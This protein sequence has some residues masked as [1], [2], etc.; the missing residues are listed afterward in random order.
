VPLLGLALLATMALAIVAIIPQPSALSTRVDGVIPRMAIRLGPSAPDIVDL[1]VGD[2]A[3]YTLD[4][5]EGAVRAFSLD[6]LEQQPTPETLLARAGTALDSLG[7]QLALPIAI[8]YLRGPPNEPGSLAIVDQSRAVIQVGN[9]RTLSAHA[10]STSADWQ[11]LGALGSG[12]K[13]ELL[14]LDSGAQQVLAYPAL[15]RTVVDA[16]RLLFDASSAPRLPFDRV[17]QI[18]SA[19]QSL[20]VRLDDGS[21][22]RLGTGG[23]E[24]T[25]AIQSGDTRPLVT[26]A[27]APDRRG[28]LYLADPRNARIVQSDLQGTV[29]RELRAPELAAVR[30]MDVDLDGSRLY[31]LI[32]SGVVVVDIPAE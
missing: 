8:E 1:A 29:L 14:F 6:Q 5:A 12:E 22:Q 26:T 10:M 24:Q 15:D 32:D 28:G 25:I 9:D 17:A 21:V 16:P 2:S 19:G 4:V 3:L 18:L 31:A 7:G 30:A 11:Q 27:M 20:V 13:G 23:A